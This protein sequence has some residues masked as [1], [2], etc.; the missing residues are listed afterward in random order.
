MT[1]EVDEKYPDVMGRYWYVLCKN[2]I[3]GT[4]VLTV[5]RRMMGGI[6]VYAQAIYEG[7]E[8]ATVLLKDGFT[9]IYSGI[10]K[11]VLT[12]VTE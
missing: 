11:S 8:T 1:F 12:G 7:G 5:A 6:D 4:T 9:T 3:K 2:D 10:S